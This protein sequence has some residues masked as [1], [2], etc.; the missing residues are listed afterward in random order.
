VGRL[1][2]IGTESWADDDGFRP[3]RSWRSVDVPDAD[4]AEDRDEL[5]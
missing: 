2:E 1:G 5:G 4:S 3:P